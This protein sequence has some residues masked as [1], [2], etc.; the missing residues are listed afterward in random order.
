ML[1]RVFLQNDTLRI[2]NQDSKL[3]P[4]GNDR[5][6][7]LATRQKVIVSFTSPISGQP[8]EMIVVV[9]DE[10]PGVS[11]AAEP[12][13]PSPA[14]L[15]SY[16]GTYFSEDADYE[17]VLKIENDG[18][19]MWDPRTW[20]EFAFRPVVRDV[21]Q[22]EG[23]TFTFSRDGQGRVVGFAVDAGRLRNSKFVRR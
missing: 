12:A 1:R 9:D 22:A 4:L 17:W 11:H 10:P 8:G 20:Y 6:Q 15:Q 19:S 2:V 14:E 18:L 7:L 3:V 5:F 13:S 21:F 23:Y 16:L